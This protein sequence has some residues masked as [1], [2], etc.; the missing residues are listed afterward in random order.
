MSDPIIENAIIKSV[1]LSDEDRGLLSGWVYLEYNSG[2]Q[3]FGGYALYLPKSYAH[4][5]VL[6][7]AGHWIWRVMQV[8]GVGNWN[9]VP[10]KTVRVRH[11]W[12]T[13]EA[14]GHITKDDWFDPKKE[15]SAG[16]LTQ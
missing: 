13:V 10:G 11:T 6:S 4:H 15:F 12:D 8:A 7:H 1:S 14:I 5:N 16:K 3:G 9:D 2:G